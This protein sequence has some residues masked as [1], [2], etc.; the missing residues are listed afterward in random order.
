[1]AQIP[2]TVIAAK[3]TTGDTTNTFPVADQNEIQGGIHYKTSIAERDAIPDTRRYRGME[4]HVADNDTTYKLIGGILNS[5]WVLQ[6]GPGAL[7]PDGVA[8]NDTYFITYRN[9]VPCSI[10][11]AELVAYLQTVIVGGVPPTGN[12]FTFGDGTV[13]AFGNG[14]EIA[15]GT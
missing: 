2:G 4:C 15:Y 12:V 5:H 8:D 11:M 14:E 9:G 13:I 3:V 10:S 1:M 7:F 6:L